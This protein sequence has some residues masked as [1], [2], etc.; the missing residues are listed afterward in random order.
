MRALKRVLAVTAFAAPL[1]LGCAG[2]ASAQDSVAAHFSEDQFAA[3][4]NGAGETEESSVVSPYG[5]YHTDFGVWADDTGVSGG[6]SDADAIWQD[7]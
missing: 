7:S 3:N 6:F 5:V 2:F 4:Q 1:A